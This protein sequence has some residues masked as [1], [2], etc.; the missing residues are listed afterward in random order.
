MKTRNDLIEHCKK[1]LEDKVM[2][3][4]GAKMQVLTS[5]QIKA[6]QNTYGRSY[7]W[8]SDL[9]KAGKMCCDCSGL[10]SSCTGFM[11]GSSGY[12]V[13]A[14]ECVPIS[15]LN[16]ENWS[17]YIG[18]G[19]W[20]SGH[21]GVVSEKYGYYYAM[22]GSARN[23]VHFPLSK[24]NFQ[25]AIKLCDI[26]YSQPY[27]EKEDK[28]QPKKENELKENEI[29]IKVN[30]KV[31]KIDRILKDNKNYI[32]VQGLANV[33]FDVDYNADTKLISVSNKVQ[34]IGVRLGSGEIKTLQSVNIDGF[35]YVK[36]RDI[37]EAVKTF[38][39]EFKNGEIHLK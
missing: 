11:R 22:D 10:I 15:S 3:V 9:G 17:S 16:K 30:G 33:G 29:F 25:Y 1:A 12:K 36:I 21:I 38:A 23:M 37:A 4:Y 13:T 19:L 8:D 7:V 28:P 31:Y 35:N 5:S 26:D 27:K 14:K 6:L 24:N 34:N 39:V 32:A 20:L 2:Y 18:W